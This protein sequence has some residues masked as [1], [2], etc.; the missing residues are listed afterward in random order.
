ML[1]ER[2]GL[3]YYMVSCQLQQGCKQISM[4]PFTD[5]QLAEFKEAFHRVRRDVEDS[6]NMDVL[7][8]VFSTLGQN[9]TGEYLD[10]LVERNK[11]RKE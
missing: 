8:D 3:K 9:M 1:L 10:M 2:S 6:V 7:K 11:G 4:N 5:L